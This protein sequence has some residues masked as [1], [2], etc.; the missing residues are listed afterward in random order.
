MST[1]KTWRDAKTFDDLTA[2][3]IVG[4][5]FPGQTASESEIVEAIKDSLEKLERG[6]FEDVTDKPEVFGESND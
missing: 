2:V 1:K 5:R 6:E 3:G 4:Y